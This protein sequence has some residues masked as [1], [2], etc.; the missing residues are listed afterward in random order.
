MSPHR[1]E[2]ITKKHLRVTRMHNFRPRVKVP[3]IQFIDDTLKQG[4]TKFDI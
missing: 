3:N 1:Y 2:K 4:F